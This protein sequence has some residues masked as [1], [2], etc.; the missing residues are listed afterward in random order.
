MG[1]HPEHLTALIGEDSRRAVVIANALDD[2]PAD[3]HRA[4]VERE[5]AALADLGIDAIELD[6]RDFF[7]QEQR[8]RRDLGE[9]SL[10]WLRGGNVFMLRY[11]LRCSGAD[12]VFGHLL[13]ADA[14]VYRIQ[15]WPVRAVPKPAWPLSCLMMLESGGPPARSRC[16]TA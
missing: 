12:T 7:G 6:L 16:G 10:A 15:R 2:A 9:V 11:A 14:L 13:A 3:V 8:V 4:G 1:D 5:L